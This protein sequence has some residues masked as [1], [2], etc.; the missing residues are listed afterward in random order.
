VVVATKES[1]LPFMDKIFNNG[2]ANNTEGLE[3]ITAAQVKEI[4]PFVQGIAGFMGSCNG[5][6][7]F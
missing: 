1:E 7:R 4:E 6:Y 3:K 2:I 5:N